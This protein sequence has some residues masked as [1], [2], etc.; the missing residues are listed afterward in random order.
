MGWPSSLKRRD[1]QSHNHDPKSLAV[2]KVTGPRW[3]ELLDPEFEDSVMAVKE[4]LR[5]CEFDLSDGV[6]TGEILV[7]MKDSSNE[8]VEITWQIIESTNKTIQ[9]R[10]VTTDQVKDD[11]SSSVYRA[12]LINHANRQIA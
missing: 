2:T 9:V 11:T 6:P 12:I 7:R 4:G 1:L 5:S 10:L 8:V 3:L